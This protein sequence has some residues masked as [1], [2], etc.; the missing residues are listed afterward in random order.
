MSKNT[1][2]EIG[3][4]LTV[5]AEILQQQFSSSALMVMAEDL[6][7]YGLEPVKSALARVRRECS[8]LT[9]QAIIER[10]DDGRPNVEEAWA[11]LPRNES[12][13]IVWTEEMAAAYGVCSPLLA[14][15]EKVAARMAFKEAY[16][17][18]LAQARAQVK[19]AKWSATLGSDKAGREEALKLAVETG[20]LNADYARQLLPDSS[21]RIT[22]GGR[23]LLGGV[24][25]AIALL[26]SGDKPNYSK[27]SEHASRLIEE[28]W[29]GK[30]VYK[31]QKIQH[32]LAVGSLSPCGTARFIGGDPADP[33]AWEV[34]VGEML[35]SVNKLKGAA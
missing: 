24:S 10:I 4:A 29:G 30:S 27:N 12:Q 20:K 3:K 23:K 26:E 6:E 31:P 7:V 8:R 25:Q 19:P 18:L 2:T 16:T 15:G 33:N 34:V 14:D 35:G 32:S 13:T 17:T 9:L 21:Y 11:M 28:I 5:T 1:L 22:T